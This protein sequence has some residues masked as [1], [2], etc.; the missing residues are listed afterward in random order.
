M[1]V[2]LLDISSKQQMDEQREYL[3][4]RL[5]TPRSDLPLA[6]VEAVKKLSSSAPEAAP[7]R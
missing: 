1:L 2:D 5:F 6:T 4:L 7:V 3:A